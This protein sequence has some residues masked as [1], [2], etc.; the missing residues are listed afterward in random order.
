MTRRLLPDGTVHWAFAPK[1]HVALRAAC[2]AG[3]MPRSSTAKRAKVTCPACL[4]LP[5]EWKP[6]LGYNTRPLSKPGKG[7]RSAQGRDRRGS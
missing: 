6:V 4:R 5:E 2:G 1:G 3:A 7:W